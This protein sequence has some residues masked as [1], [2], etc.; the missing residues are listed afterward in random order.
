V[1][2]LS[3]VSNGYPLDPELP[4]AREDVLVGEDK[5]HR[6]GQLRRA[7]LAVKKR[8]SYGCRHLSESARAQWIAAHPWA[9]SYSHT[10]ELGVTRTVVTTARSDTLIRTE[11]GTSGTPAYYDVQV[12]VEE[13]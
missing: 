13:V 1:A 3:I 8:I 12:T 10:D 11:P 5:R 6:S 9:G 7:H 4:V 2:T